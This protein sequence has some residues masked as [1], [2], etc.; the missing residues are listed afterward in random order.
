MCQALYKHT[1][2]FFLTDIFPVRDYHLHFTDGQTKVQRGE[3]TGPKS[4]SNG[5]DLNPGLA[6][7]QDHAL[8][9]VVHTYSQAPPVSPTRSPS[10]V[11]QVSEST[12][13]PCPPQYPAQSQ[14]DRWTECLGASR[15][16]GQLLLP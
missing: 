3:A 16:G 8:C 14:T 9:T 4:H 12:H 10:K 15:N 11:R 5:P 7:P 1:A 2:S 6:E 13:H